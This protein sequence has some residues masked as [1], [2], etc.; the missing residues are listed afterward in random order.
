MLHIALSLAYIFSYPAAQ[1]R[2]PTFAILLVIKSAMPRGA[3]RDEILSCFSQE[4][5]MGPRV[6]DL[7]TET[8]VKNKQGWLELSRKG[9]ILIKGFKIFRKLSALPMGRG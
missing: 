2:C 9:R 3:T 8:L 1:A 5:V 6:H 7:V 4:E